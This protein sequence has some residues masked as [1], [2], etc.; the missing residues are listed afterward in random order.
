MELFDEVVI[1]GTG[2]DSTLFAKDNALDLRVKLNEEELITSYSSFDAPV[3][4]TDQRV[5]L[6]SRKIFARGIDAKAFA[7]AIMEKAFAVNRAK[8]SILRRN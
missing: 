6:T 4:I 2:Q 5:H 3:K 1:E 8:R 7:D